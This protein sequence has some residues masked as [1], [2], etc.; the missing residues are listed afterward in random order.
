M[1][2]FGN[3]F[4]KYF[5]NYFGSVG[6]QPTPTPAPKTVWRRLVKCWW[7]EPYQEPPESIPSPAVRTGCLDINDG[8]FVR[9]CISDEFTSIVSVNDRLA[10]TVCINDSTC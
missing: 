9:V 1:S 2:F 4:G 6:S 5:G 3:Y 7:E 10:A 8:L